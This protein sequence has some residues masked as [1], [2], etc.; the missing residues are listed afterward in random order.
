M[1]V[2]MC[3]YT[4]VCV[5]GDLFVQPPSG[6]PGTLTTVMP[7]AQQ[8]L[9][10]LASC[11]DPCESSDL[12]KIKASKTKGKRKTV[13]LFRAKCNTRIACWNVRTLGSL[14][15]QSLQLMS[16]LRTMKEKNIEVLA[17][18]ESRWTG[19]GVTKIGSY[20][21]LHSGTSS[22]HV[23]GVAIIMSSKAA[24]SWEAAN[25]IYSCIGAYHQNQGQ[26]TSWLQPI[27]AVYAPVNP[28]NAT[29]GARASADA[30]YEQLHSTLASVPSCDMTLI[31]GDFNAHVGSRS[32]QWRSV[33]GPH[34]PDELDENG[35]RLLDFCA[36]NN[37][38]VSNTWFQHKPI[39]QLTWY[40]NGDQS[41]AGHM[42]DLVL[43][44]RK[45]R[46]SMLDTRV[47]RAT[48]LQSDHEL[49]ISTIR[50]KIKSRS[51][52]HR[53]NPRIQTQGLSKE[54]VQL[55][56]QSILSDAYDHSHQ[57]ATGV[58]S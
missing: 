3:V 12:Q 51:L 1:Y 31:L 5:W 13:S 58:D 33:I 56:F 49:V 38:I 41:K 44:N 8:G 16:A 11:P 46:S 24:A 53:K 17:V 30:F 4:Y 43:I 57:H 35:E 25:S 27:I 39:H 37:L 7:I 42:I 50:F 32:S 2:C 19:H 28:P 6:I 52:Q 26:D 14:S 29:S 48:H 34:G 23:H 9:D 15:Q 22:T 47:F 10:R 45:F 40:R 18:S 21:I 20:T 54:S 36:T 55:N